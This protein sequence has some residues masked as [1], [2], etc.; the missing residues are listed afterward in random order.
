MEA[1]GDALTVAAGEGIVRLLSLQVEGGRPVTAR[2]FIA[3]QRV[4]P[5]A[6]FGTTA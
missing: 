6:L 4:S 1:A 2:E 5:G 3:G